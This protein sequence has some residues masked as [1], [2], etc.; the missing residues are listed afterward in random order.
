[1]ARMNYRSPTSSRPCFMRCDHQ[2]MNPARSIASA[3]R[4]WIL[5]RRAGGGVGAAD[6]AACE[7]C[8]AA[9]RLLGYRTPAFGA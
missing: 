9:A 3:R 6:G 2:L 7:A 4:A 8:G 1:M 5:L